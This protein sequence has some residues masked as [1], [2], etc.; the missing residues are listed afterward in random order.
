[1]GSCSWPTNARG[2]RRPASSTPASAGWEVWVQA[3]KG[4]SVKQSE[5]MARFTTSNVLLEAAHVVYFGVVVNKDVAVFALLHNAAKRVAA[6]QI[7]FRR[8][9]GRARMRRQIRGI[10]SR[11]AHRLRRFSP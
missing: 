4:P 6:V 3:A 1:M 8:S 5:R 9:V 7:R 2:Q 11:A 10:E